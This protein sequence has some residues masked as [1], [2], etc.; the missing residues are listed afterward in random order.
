MVALNGHRLP[1]AKKLRQ[2]RRVGRDPSRLI[3]RQQLGRCSRNQ[4]ASRQVVAGNS[5]SSALSCN[6]AGLRSPSIASRNTRQ[7]GGFTVLL[8][9]RGENKMS[10]SY[11]AV[12][13]LIF[14]IVAI[15]HLVRIING[16]SVAIGP[17]NIPMSVSWAG[18]VVAALLAL[19]GVAQI[20]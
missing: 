4:L 6:R 7:L 9:E 1:L 15:M 20:G 12:T 8:L 5:R 3:L 11:A 19:W 10:N 14:A 18:L 2:L 17:H 16:W 13:V